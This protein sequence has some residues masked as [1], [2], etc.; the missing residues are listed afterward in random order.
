MKR[1]FAHVLVAGALLAVLA[2]ACGDDDPVTGT[3]N[4]NNVWVSLQA[5]PADL[6]PTSTYDNALNQTYHNL[7]WTIANA[8]IPGYA[9][10]DR[11]GLAKVTAHECPGLLGG[12]DRDREEF[13]QLRGGA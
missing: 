6:T 2:M 9:P 3:S 11:F 12:L 4:G 10:G 13:G 1:L 8:T 5:R 7:T